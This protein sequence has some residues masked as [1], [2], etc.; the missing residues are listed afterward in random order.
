MTVL[1]YWKNSSLSFVIQ[2]NKSSPI[3][4]L[5]R[6]SPLWRKV[7]FKYLAYAGYFYF[8]GFM[9]FKFFKR[10]N[11]QPQ[12]RRRSLSFLRRRSRSSREEPRNEDFLRPRR[13]GEGSEEARTSREIGSVL[14]EI[15]DELNNS[16][17]SLNSATAT[18]W[19]IGKHEWPSCQN[20]TNGKRN[21][22]LLGPIWTSSQ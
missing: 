21:S 16:T 7:Y 6:L 22:S 4:M 20:G 3:F 14:R 13:S 2:R 15:G 12:S 8:A 18:K 17:L 9:G 19:R 1:Y 5:G 10:T 11:S